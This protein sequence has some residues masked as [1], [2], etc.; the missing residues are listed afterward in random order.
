MA[1]L[2]LYARIINTQLQGVYF[3]SDEDDSEGITHCYSRHRLKGSYH[4]F[5]NPNYSPRI[6][7]QLINNKWFRCNDDIMQPYF[8]NP[9]KISRIIVLSLFDHFLQYYDFFWYS[10]TKHVCH[11]NHI[12]LF[13]M[14]F[15]MWRKKSC[16]I[17]QKRCFKWHPLWVSS[18]ACP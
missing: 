6:W 8:S 10:Q 4:L 11:I 9:L 1:K 15:T 14:G 2:Y 13:K 12:R 18:L 7:K 17:S 3:P 16:L 5:F